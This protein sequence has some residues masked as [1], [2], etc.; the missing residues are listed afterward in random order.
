[1]ADQAADKD[2][3]TAAVVEKIRARV[4]KRW[5]GISVGVLWVWAGGQRRFSFRWDREASCH[6]LTKKFGADERRV[7]C[8]MSYSGL[9]D[10]IDV[11]A[12]KRGRKT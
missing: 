1:M 3:P 6:Q 5:S 12:S 11:L 2:P 9:I 7:L 4:T 10:E 8:A